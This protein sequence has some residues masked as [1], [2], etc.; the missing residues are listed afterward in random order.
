MTD[1]K[2]KPG[3]EAID[4]PEPVEEVLICPKC[5]NYKIQL[6]NSTQDQVGQAMLRLIC[7]ICGFSFVHNVIAKYS[8]PSHPDQ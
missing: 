4:K 1:N 2:T 8:K 5:K 7:M 3:D 6:I